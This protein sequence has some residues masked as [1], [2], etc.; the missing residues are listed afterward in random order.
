MARLIAL[1]FLIILLGA[2]LLSA[3]L[4]QDA[5][6]EPAD[7]AGAADSAA[8][9]DG[10]EEDDE[11]PDD[12]RSDLE[13]EPPDFEAAPPAGRPGSLPVS[14][15]HWY[16]TTH[17]SVEFSFSKEKDVGNWDARIALNQQFGAKFTARLN[18]SIRNHENTTLNRADASDGTS[19][20]LSYQLNPDVS[21]S[22]NYNSTVLANW[23][24]LKGGAPDDRKK[25]GSFTV[26]ADMSKA[27]T[28]GLGLRVHFGGGA[29]QNSYTNQR[30][31]GNQGDLGASMTFNPLGSSLRASADYTSKQ[32]FLNSE[33]ADSTGALTLETKDKTVSQNL[34]FNVG[35]DLFPGMRVGT[36]FLANDEQ[37]QRPEQLTNEQETERNKRRGVSVNTN[38]RFSDRFTWEAAVSLS[39]SKRRFLVRY[40]RNS[41]V[42]NAAIN[43]SMK[44][45]PW[46]GATL[47]MGGKW[48]DARS[49]YITADTG[50]S[51]Q[52][53]LSL[54]YAQKLGPKA[55]VSFSALSDLSVT[56]YD[57]KVANFKDRDLLTNRYRLDFGYKL[58]PRISLSLGGEF[59]DETNVYTQSKQSASNRN[60]E[61]YRVTGAYDIKTWKSVSIN[62]RYEI[63]QVFT[64]YHY[65]DTRNTLVRN[66]NINTSVDFKI[67]S[68]L[69]LN[70]RHNYKY[71]D[72]GSYRREGGQRLYG[73]ATES[74]S[75]L[76]SIA[77]NYK[78]GKHLNFRI[79]QGFFT[80]TRWKYQDDGSKEL[81]YVVQNTDISGRVGFNYKIGDTSELA[82]HVEHNR[83]EGD[84][85]NAAFR[86]YW[87][88]EIRAKHI[89]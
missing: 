13:T 53:S 3:C 5:D 36:N 54:K 1:Q 61:R 57:D 31:S 25:R 85:V 77:V 35:F 26:A 7:S 41:D 8:V 24:N 48:S 39:R 47:S 89:F 6:G 15:E 71:Q 44:I 21:F 74:E 19:A 20:S 11:S 80:D 70:L 43:G 73:R 18:A 87:N 75:H 16:D 23:Y 66:S 49:E 83:K 17:P 72:Q 37:K 55:D 60:A 78:M 34:S 10:F 4:A 81:E 50:N 63:S 45:I 65:D 59:S 51:I 27:L 38:Y 9:V 29:T 62:Q 86:N 69:G 52:K 14:Y 64:D 46:S 82:F 32:S 28:S 79:R 76:L 33:L 22:L 68:S 30:N 42:N 12:E 2:G 84:R 58:R 40:D 67:V 88:A 56:A